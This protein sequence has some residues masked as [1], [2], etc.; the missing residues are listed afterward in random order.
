MSRGIGAGTG[1]A[2]QPFVNMS[3]PESLSHARWL[4]KKAAR[5]GVAISSLAPPALAW[6]GPGR[7]RPMVRALTYHRFGDAAR[8]PYCLDVRAFEK[9]MAFLCAKRLAVSLENVQEFVSGK[10]SLRNGSVLVTIDD[11]FRSTFRVLPILQHYQIPAVTFISPGKIP[12]AGGAKQA[13]DGPEAYMT[14]SEIEGLAKS[15]LT[16]GSHAWSHRS[17]GRMSPAEVH[18]ET[19]RSRETLA[20]R[21]GHGVVSFAYPFGRRSDFN[22]VTAAAL[23]RCGYSCA[24]TSQHGAIRPGLDPFTLPRIKIESGEGS[25]LFRRA[26]RGGLDRWRWVDQHLGRLQRRAT[27]T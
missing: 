14:W 16:I 4:A 18:D 22:D 23:M 24:F 11:G 20:K 12:T 17:L 27:Q 19:W 10:R 6:M 8:D 3:S 26:S 13:S 9:Q 25:W 15:G 21:L 1:A 2:A 7:H 5:N